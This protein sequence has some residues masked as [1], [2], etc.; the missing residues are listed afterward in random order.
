MRSLSAL[1]YI[2]TAIGA[3]IRPIKAG[4]GLVYLEDVEADE[5]GKQWVRAYI[6]DGKK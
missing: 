3:G 1:L 6:K 2:V 4:E 5:E